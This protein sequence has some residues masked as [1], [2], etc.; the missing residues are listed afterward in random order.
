MELS[1]ICA[2]MQSILYNLNFQDQRNIN[3]VN[4]VKDKPKLK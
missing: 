4:E 1:Q 3:R 2:K